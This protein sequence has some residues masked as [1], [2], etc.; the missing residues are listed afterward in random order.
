MNITEIKIKLMQNRADRLRAFCTMAIDHCFLIRDLRIIDG[1]KGVFVAMPSRKLS[2]RCP[3]CSAKNHLRARFCNECGRRLDEDRAAAIPEARRKYHVDI[4]HPINS[5][6]RQELQERILR[7]FEEELERS[8]APG[9]KPV[10]LGEPDEEDYEY[11]EH[12]HRPASHE[13]PDAEPK[14]ETPKPPSPHEFGEGIV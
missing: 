1:A 8:K 6:C 14:A 3:T 2:D 5:R 7:A 11:A 9:Y 4:A 10:E 13:Q 12:E